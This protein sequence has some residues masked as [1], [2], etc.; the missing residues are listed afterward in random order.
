MGASCQV[1]GSPSP[2][3]AWARRSIL[4]P[5]LPQ[6]P[7][8]PPPT[9]PA[10]ERGS[11]ALEPVLTLETGL[12]D[13][14]CRAAEPAG[15]LFQIRQLSVH[16]YSGRPGTFLSRTAHRSSAPGYPSNA[17]ACPL[18]FLA[19]LLLLSFCWANRPYRYVDESCFLYFQS[20][21]PAGKIL[22]S[23]FTLAALNTPCLP[24]RTI[25]EALKENGALRQLE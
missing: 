7:H 11:A 1:C 4:S 20:F 9:V 3:K 22:V 21:I 17:T 19:A 13:H 2:A 12:L 24:L 23:T 14:R 6:P 10:I 5:S 15:H 25:S 18:A 16:G 8:S